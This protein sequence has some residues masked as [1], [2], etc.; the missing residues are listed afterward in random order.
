[1]QAAI[2]RAVDK[3]KEEIRNEVRAELQGAQ[4]AAAFMGTVAERQPKVELFELDGYYRVRAQMLNKLNLRGQ[5]DSAGFNY[6]PKP[7]RA[8]STIETTNMRLRLEPTINA[9]ESVRVRAQIDVLDNW[10]LGS[11]PG[12][13]SDNL[14]PDL[15]SHSDTTYPVP[16]YGST[17]TYTPGD[18][19]N[20]RDPIIPRRV[21]G[22]FQTPLGLLSFGRMPSSWGLGI[23]ANAGTGLDQDFGDT[24]DRIQVALPPVGTP[25]GQLV[26]V[27]IFDFDITGVAMHDP[28]GGAGQGQPLDA[29]PGADARTLAFKV[30]RLDTEDDIRRKLDRGE[31]SVNYGLYFNH[32]AQRYVYPSWLDQGY[33][34][35]YNPAST[36]SAT[37]SRRGASANFA[38]LWFRFLGPRLRVESEVVGLY[39]S[40]GNANAGSNEALAP[41]HLH[42]RQ[43]GGV[44]QVEAKASGKFSYGAELGAASGDGAPGFGNDPTRGTFADPNVLP[45]YGAIEGPQWGRPGDDSINNFRFNPAYTVDLIFYRRILGQVTDSI[46]LRPNTRWEIINGLVLNTS[47]LYAQAQCPSS[48]PSSSSAGPGENS[49]LDQ[50][51][52]R[53]LALELDNTLTLTPTHG[54]TGW[55]DFGLLKPLAGMGTGTSMAW[56]IDLGLAATF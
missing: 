18:K 7:F 23:L 52:K 22:E 27:P 56:M 33:S 50:K 51:G 24:V 40:I 13:V 11:N 9:S 47:L 19:T 53:P 20:D 4:S 36:G 17:R 15:T 1:V 31:R 43:W 29:D 30:V 54:F 2:Q 10:I 35:N 55:M 32:R 45:N 16:F 26:F 41:A 6:F 25:I 48:T 28:H 12:Q 44:L 8:G 14:N 3:A 37:F 39:G 42:M 46:Y 5:P 34:G 38:S 49:P 21:W